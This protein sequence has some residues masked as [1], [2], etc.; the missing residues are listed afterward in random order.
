MIYDSFAVAVSG[1]PDSLALAFLAKVYSIK[2]NLR[3]KYLI[4][5]HKIR[6]E[7]TYEAQKVKK[8]LSNFG[9]DAEILTWKGKKPKS[10]VQSLARKKDM[11]YYLKNVKV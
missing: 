3:S 9:I 2:Y 5:D 8:I 6:N 4:V 7:S 1:G 10:N 11:T